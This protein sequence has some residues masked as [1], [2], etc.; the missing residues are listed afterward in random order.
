MLAV[1]TP[2][3]AGEVGWGLFV[4]TGTGWAHFAWRRVT[5]KMATSGLVVGRYR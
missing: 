3:A 5:W 1:L 4:R 2:L